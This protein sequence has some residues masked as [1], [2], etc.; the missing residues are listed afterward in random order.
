ASASVV[1]G[2]VYAGYTCNGGGAVE[3]FSAAG[4]PTY[5]TGT[6]PFKTCSPIWDGEGVN[7]LFPAVVGGEVYMGGD[8]GLL[9]VFSATPDLT[10]CPASG[11]PPVK[12]CAALWV[13]TTGTPFGTSSPAVAN[14]VIFVGGSDGKLDVFSAT[15]D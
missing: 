2:V 9:H 5:C 3:T 14:G 1:G 7:G 13:G 11:T 6:S 4:S 15:P 12:T 10:K 8:G